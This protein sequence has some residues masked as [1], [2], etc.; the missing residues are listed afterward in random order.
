MDHITSDTS[1]QTE[2]VYILHSA[3]VLAI[4]LGGVVSA[5]IAARTLSCRL[6][7][8]IPRKLTDPDNKEQ[9]IGAIMEDG[10]VAITKGKQRCLLAC[11]Q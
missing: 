6:G 10:S 7:I 2:Y 9:A 4:P 8:I 1:Y 5:D 3:I 11:G